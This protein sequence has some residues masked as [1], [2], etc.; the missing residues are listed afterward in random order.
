MA[1]KT[2]QGL[3]LKSDLRGGFKGRSEIGIIRSTTQGFLKEG[4]V[5]KPQKGRI[6]TVPYLAPADTAPFSSLGPGPKP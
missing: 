2:L 5:L 4:A 3:V 1:E 6:L